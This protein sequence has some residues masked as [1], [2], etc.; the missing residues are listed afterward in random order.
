MSRYFLM[1]LLFAIIA[2]G[3]VVLYG[4]GT[5]SELVARG[6]FGVGFLGAVASIAIAFARESTDSSP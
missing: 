4:I 5:V 2:V 3:G 6:A 1:A